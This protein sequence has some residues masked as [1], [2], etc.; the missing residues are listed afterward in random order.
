MTPSS[1]AGRRASERSVPSDSTDPTG[2]ADG[3]GPE[4]AGGWAGPGIWKT[5]AA[6]SRSVGMVVTPSR[7]RR[8]GPVIQL[9]EDGPASQRDGQRRSQHWALAT[10]TKSTWLRRT[11]RRAVV[12]PISY[13][14]GLFYQD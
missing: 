10:R 6:A 9:R 2:R 14:L 8:A 3:P 11:K 5:R 7:A 4:S 13:L 1:S 12:T